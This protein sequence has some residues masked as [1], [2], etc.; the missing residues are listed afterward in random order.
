[1][2]KQTIKGQCGKCCE[3]KS[4]RFHESM[5]GPLSPD[6]WQ[7]EVMKGSREDLKI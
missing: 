7:Q 3:K 2:G 5:W 1:M 6:L 4:L